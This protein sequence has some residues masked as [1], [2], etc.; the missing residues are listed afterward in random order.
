MSDDVSHDYLR[1]KPKPYYKSRPKKETEPG[2]RLVGNTKLTE[3]QWIELET[4]YLS[5]KT[6]VEL[7]AKYGINQS[8]ISRRLT[9]SINQVTA[10]AHDL[11]NGDISPE[12]QV[13]Q[14]ANKARTQLETLAPSNQERAKRLVEKLKTI[15]TELV[16]AAE[17]G[18]RTAHTLSSMAHNETKKFDLE[19]PT[20]RN[21]IV[22]RNVMAL[23][24]AAN[25]AAEM[26]LGLLAGNKE[27]NAAALKETEGNTDFA[28]ISPI[29]ASRAYQKMLSSK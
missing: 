15:S 2:K 21:D 18:A 19:D 16:G 6:S 22:A 17:F 12:P 4:E 10:I 13:Q 1:P 7:A 24:V 28:G 23:T 29:D 8:T 3:T 25:K 26:G 20:A 5:G 9:Q 14:L 11:F 27:L